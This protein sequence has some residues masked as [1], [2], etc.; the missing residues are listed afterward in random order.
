LVRRRARG[1]EA[2]TS[3]RPAP[4]ARQ[5]G[6]IERWLRIIER[7]NGICGHREQ[8]RECIDRLYWRRLHKFGLDRLGLGLIGFR[9]RLRGRR[10]RRRRFRRRRSRRRRR[11]HGR[12]RIWRRRCRR[13]DRRRRR[14]RLAPALGRLVGLIS[15]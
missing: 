15:G 9:L 8:L 14:R 11:R 13:R 3:Y 10:S 12:W 1:V 7:G 5:A 6:L 4:A 2:R